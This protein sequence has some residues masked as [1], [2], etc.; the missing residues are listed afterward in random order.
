MS[1]YLLFSMGVTASA[2]Y[3]HGEQV[4]FELFSTEPEHCGGSQDKCSMKGCCSDK[5]ERVV[6]EDQHL[7]SKAYLPDLCGVYGVELDFQD[8]LLLWQI[9]RPDPTLFLSPFSEETG[10]PPG[11]G[12]PIYLQCCSLRI[13]GAHLG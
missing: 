8:L 12:I 7:I 2:H 10:R 11:T 5:V 13:D 4:S 1:L 9:Q 6:L 3:C